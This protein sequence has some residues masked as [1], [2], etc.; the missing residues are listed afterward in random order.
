MYGF[1]TDFFHLAQC[2][3]DAKWTNLL[4]SL[5]AKKSILFKSKLRELPGKHTL[6][7]E[8]SAP[9]SESFL[10][11]YILFTSCKSSKDYGL[12]CRQESQVLS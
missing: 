8:E 10:Q 5:K 6:D 12:A 7:R 3:A 1:V 9:E 2:F 11:S 4:E